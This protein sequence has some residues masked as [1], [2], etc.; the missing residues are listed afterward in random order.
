MVLRGCGDEGPK[1]DG[2]NVPSE[3]LAR[4][5]DLLVDLVDLAHADL[6]APF[7]RFASPPPPF[8][9]YRIRPGS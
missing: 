5:G 2:A 1:G 4:G 6:V 9:N 3:L 8:P 7:S